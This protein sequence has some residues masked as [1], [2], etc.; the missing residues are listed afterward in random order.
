MKLGETWKRETFHMNI[1]TI[2]FVG[3]TWKNENL[4]T[5]KHN[6][7]TIALRARNVFSSKVIM[8]AR[9]DIL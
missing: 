7:I 2:K 4:V 1:S 6:M 3:K 8:F 9:L 5:L